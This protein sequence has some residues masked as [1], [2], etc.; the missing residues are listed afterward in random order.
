MFQ[1]MQHILD[2]RDAILDTGRKMRARY[3]SMV[4]SSK[5]PLTAVSVNISRA[6]G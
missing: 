1:N 4:S 6:I 3:R 2:R 5:R